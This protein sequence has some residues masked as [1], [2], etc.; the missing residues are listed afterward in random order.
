L[1]NESRGTHSDW[2]SSLA[3]TQVFPQKNGRAALGPAK[4]ASSAGALADFLKLF[5]GRWRELVHSSSPGKAG[6]GPESEDLILLGEAE[7]GV[8]SHSSELANM[9]ETHHSSSDNAWFTRRERQEHAL[10]EEDLTRWELASD[11]TDQWRLASSVLPPEGDEVTTVAALEASASAQASVSASTV[12]P[13]SSPSA[14]STVGTAWSNVFMSVDKLAGSSVLMGA[15]S[16]VVIRQAAQSTPDITPP[17]IGVTSTRTSFD[18]GDTATVTFTLSEA[19]TNLAVNS[20]TVTGGV[21]SNFSGSGTTY[22]ATFT[23]T[24]NSTAAGSVSVASGKFSD[25]AGNLNAD[26]ADANNRVNFSVDTALPVAPLA[27]LD[28][29]WSVNPQ[30]TLRVNMGGGVTQDVVVEVYPNEVGL[31]VS[32][33]L[34]YVNTDFYNGLIFHRV[35]PGFVVQAG[36]FTSELVQK[37]PTYDPVTLESGVHGLSNLT[38]TIAMA[39]TDVP[40]SA[41]SQFYF[42]LVDN[43]TSLDY[44]SANSPGYAVFGRVVSGAGTLHTIAGVATSTQSGMQSVPVSAITL[45]D[46]SVTQAGHAYS[47]SGVIYLGGLEPSGQWSYSLDGGNAWVPIT[48]AEIDL[49]TTPGDKVVTIRQIDSAGNVSATSMVAFTQYTPDDVNS[50]LDLTT[51]SDTVGGD[52]GTDHDNVTQ[53]SSLLLTAFLADW[54][55][56]DVWLMDQGHYVSSATASALG[57]LNWQVV[58]ATPGSHTYT[59]YDPVNHLR[60]L[61]NGDVAVSELHVR[62]I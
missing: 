28:G 39:R 2:L 47:S 51:A 45:D 44:V 52:A 56:R 54:A 61:A 31:T 30:V 29:S 49:G 33:W 38:D 13:A 1:S 8:L 6:R 15:A 5:W 22:T 26:G 34:A 3:E 46:V 14:L 24:V 41:T 42:N 37:P 23:P 62:V 53:S 43:S 50:V 11:D 20:V 18:V 57:E 16:A 59:M 60:I 40:D 7:P 9:H 19:S 10:S 32:N 55:N 4:D 36:G 21:L 58:S 48:Q 35:I 27:M 25:A 17:M 12:L